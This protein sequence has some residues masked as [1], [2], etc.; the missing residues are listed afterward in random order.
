MAGA[1]SSVALSA[2]LGWALAFAPAVAAE[3]DSLK[4]LAR[5]KA[6]AVTIMKAKAA[7]QIARLSGD[8][9][10]VAY[11]N[12]STQGE[13]ARLRARMA[14]MLSALWNRFGLHEI[15]V[16]DRSGVLVVRVGAKRGA[17]TQF[18]VK[19]NAVL[20][21]GFA[22]K[23]FKTAAIETR[24]AVSFAAPVTVREQAEFVLS[25]R[26]DV[27]AYRKVLAYGK[28]ERFVVLVDAKGQ[29]LADTRDNAEGRAKLIAG[30]TLDGLRRAVKGSRNEGG[31][32]V[33]RGAERY[34][35]RYVAAD[36]W[37]VIAG[38]AVAVPRRCPNQGARLCG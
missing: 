30:L 11:L 29:V 4:A 34:N 18:D 24:E 19:K 21:A 7:A 12:A 28:G 20:A 6:A 3:T 16:V 25:A 13:G 1:S 33:G 27:S 31:G 8:R 35:V 38:E 36:N 37:T 5:E 32:Q 15:A 26:Q 23:P 10:F 17:P 22:R 2:I 9:V 14:S